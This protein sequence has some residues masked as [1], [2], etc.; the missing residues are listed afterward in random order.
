MFKIEKK[1]ITFR[2]KIK[3]GSK[4]IPFGSNPKRKL[5]LRSYSIQSLKKIKINFSDRSS[6]NNHKSTGFTSK[7]SVTFTK[8]KSLLNL[9][10]SKQ[11]GII[12]ILFLP[13]FNSRDFEH[14]Q[15]RFEDSMQILTKLNIDFQPQLFN[16]SWI[17]F[18]L[19]KKNSI[20]SGHRIRFCHRTCDLKCEISFETR[21]ARL[22]CENHGF[23]WLDFFLRKTV[24]K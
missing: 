2:S 21:L 12:I 20:L 24:Y 1:T 6:T 10:K 9:V 22:S 5:L 14:V 7:V 15:C 4:S 18:F 3:F 8:E 19:C 11:I 23:T 13:G 16:G 17:F